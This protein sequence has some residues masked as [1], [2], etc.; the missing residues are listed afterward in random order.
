MTIKCT[1]DCI[2]Q[3]KVKEFTK[4]NTYEVLNEWADSISENTKVI[5]D[6]NCEHY[7]GNWHKHFNKVK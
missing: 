1:K 7:L 6:T 3:L 5:D 4:G 2:S